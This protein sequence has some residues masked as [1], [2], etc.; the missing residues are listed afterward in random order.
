[1]KLLLIVRTLL[2]ATVLLY[3][4]N[5]H[6]L[7]LSKEAEISILTCSPG[8]ELYSLFGHTAVRVRDPQ[9]PIDIVFNYGT[10]DFDTPGFYLKFAQGLLPYY[11]TYTS[12]NN[13]MYAYQQDNRTVYSQT[14]Q[15]DSLEKQKLMDLLEENYLPENRSYL[16]NFLFDNCTNRSR[17]IVQKSISGNVEW[18]LTDTGKSFWNLLDEYLYI[19]PWVQWGI[20]SILGQPGTQ[21]AATYEYMF[22]PDYLMYGLDSA[23]YNNHHLATKAEILYQAPELNVR[24]PWYFNPFFVFAAGALLL[25]LL[26]QKFR[27]VQLLNLISL[28]LFLF[29]GI[30][31]ALIVFLGFFTEHPITFPNWNIL[32]AN[33]LNLLALFFILRKRSSKITNWYLL[34]YMAILIIA[35]PV[36][37]VAQPAVPLAS[38]S[39]IF[40]MIYIC[41]RLKNKYVKKNKVTIL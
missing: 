35:I 4:L 19:S 22:L 36:W 34:F 3:S 25:I 14:L 2:I 32:W 8:N 38:V 7:K 11:L 5:G 9:E 24:N 41:F 18:K 6:A 31:G 23:I 29:T 20:H 1:M 37:F 12:Y 39:L 10:F 17:D 26:L 40:L 16:Y 28:L 30:L 15:L 13:F 33:P 27:S 21:T